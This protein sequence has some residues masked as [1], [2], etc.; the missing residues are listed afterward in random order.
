MVED[1]DPA[2]T[3]G[4]GIG[5]RL[6]RAPVASYTPLVAKRGYTRDTIRGGASDW[7]VSRPFSSYFRLFGSLIA[8]PVR[9]FE[10][11]PKIPDVRAPALFL[12][13]SG[14]PAAILWLLSGG[15]YP[16]LVALLAPLPISFL[17]AWFY[18]LGSAG[19]RYGCLVTWR[20][21]AY[22]LG[23]SL[24]LSALPVVRWVA[25]A[26][27]GVVLVGVGLAVVRE[28]G[29]VRAVLTSAVVTGLLLLAIYGLL[30]R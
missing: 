17:L 15:L 29:A 9:F 10:V 5:L 2:L 7:D 8:H 6:V 19:G 20:I 14:L 18:Y 21:V 22:P 30:A 25:A 24:P 27:A 16:A 11:L 1:D 3:V 4:G 12:V 26:Y 28:I 13:F 23:F